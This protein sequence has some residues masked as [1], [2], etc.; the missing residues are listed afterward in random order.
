M[1]SSEAKKYRMDKHLQLQA[2]GCFVFCANLFVECYT[3]KEKCIS[4]V[5]VYTLLNEY[6]ICL[7]WV[8]CSTEKADGGFEPPCGPA[9]C[10]FRTEVLIL[11]EVTF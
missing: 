1:E 2:H 3:P 11:S 9:F 7:Y 5:Y 6:S 10:N 8:Y 4:V